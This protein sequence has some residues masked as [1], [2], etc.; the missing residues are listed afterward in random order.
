MTQY[1]IDNYYSFYDSNIIN[2]ELDQYIPGNI[3]NDSINFYESYEKRRNYF[4]F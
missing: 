1:P 4:N 3:I 2:I